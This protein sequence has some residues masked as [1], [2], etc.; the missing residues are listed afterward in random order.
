MH[1][2]DDVELF[3]MTIFRIPSAEMQAIEPQ[4][5]LLLE[6]VL[7]SRR[8]QCNIRMQGSAVAEKKLGQNDQRYLTGIAVGATSSNY[9][10]ATGYNMASTNVPG[11]HSAAGTLQ[12]VVCGRVSYVF[13]FTGP[14]I[15]IDTACSSSLVATHVAAQS[16]HR[17]E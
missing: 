16:V 9:N 2:L 6:S 7:Q 11:P 12:S 17:S 10:T 15:C 1:T 3:E 8:S 14:S 5:R 13:G 4:Q